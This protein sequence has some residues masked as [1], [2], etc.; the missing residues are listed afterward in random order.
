MNLWI[1]IYGFVFGGGG[2]QLEDDDV[3]ERFQF[4]V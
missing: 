2:F 4:E 3:C 1:S